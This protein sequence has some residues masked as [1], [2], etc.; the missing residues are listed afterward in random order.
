MRVGDIIDSPRAS[1]IVSPSGILFPVASRVKI[2][3]EF[4]EVIHPN[5]PFVCR[6]AYM[7]EIRLCETL[8]MPDLDPSVLLVDQLPKGEAPTGAVQH[9]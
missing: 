7:T 2:M 9:D 4:I 5:M 8:D 1:H 6:F 3:P